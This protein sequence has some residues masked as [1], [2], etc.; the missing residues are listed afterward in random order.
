[1]KLRYPVTFGSKTITELEFKRP[2]AKHFRKMPA[3]PGVGDMLDLVASLTDQPSNVIDELDAS[4]MEEALQIVGGFTAR[5][6][7]TGAT[8]SQS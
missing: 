5:G 2:K 7:E 4:D 6:P 3:A 1:M 8:P